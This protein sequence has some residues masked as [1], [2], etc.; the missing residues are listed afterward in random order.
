MEVAVNGISCVSRAHFMAG[1]PSPTTTSL[2]DLKISTHQKEVII[3]SGDAT[4]Y[5]QE[6]LTVWLLFGL[7]ELAFYPLQDSSGLMS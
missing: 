4:G 1:L 5:C 2:G 6:K 3:H 7:S